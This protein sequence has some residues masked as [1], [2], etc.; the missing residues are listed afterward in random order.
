MST[1]KLSFPAANKS[2]PSVKHEPRV[3]NKEKDIAEQEQIPTMTPLH[4]K[5]TERIKLINFAYLFSIKSRKYKYKHQKSRA[6]DLFI[7]LLGK[8]FIKSSVLKLSQP[9]PTPSPFRPNDPFQPNNS[10][11]PYIHLC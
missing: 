5:K 2:L 7:E 8:Y 1:T 6:V 10:F 9:N 3:R 4:D 11:Q